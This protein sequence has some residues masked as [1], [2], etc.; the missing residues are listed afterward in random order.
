MA[1]NDWVFPEQDKETIRRALEEKQEPA[2]GEVVRKSSGT[3][4]NLATNG[5]TTVLATTQPGENASP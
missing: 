5:M 1:R 4:G 2:A 3:S